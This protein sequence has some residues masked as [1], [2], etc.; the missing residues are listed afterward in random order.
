MQSI[1]KYHITEETVAEELR[2]LEEAKKNPAAFEP[3]YERYYDPIFRY[4]DQRVE[5][6]SSAFDITHQVFV[7]ALTHLHR[8]EFKGVPFASW[9]Y[10]IAKS[11]VYQSI[12]DQSALRARHATSEGLRDLLS[13]S[14]EEQELLLER[15]KSLSHCLT[16]LPEAEWQLIEMRFFEQRP[17]RQIAELVSMTENNAKVKVYRIL[18][19]LKKCIRLTSKAL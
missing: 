8:F 12:K 3:L 1:S 18:E 14:G 9:L 19:K 15:E 10:R 11:E 16:R 17:F 7:K 13:E 4:V 6:R 5:D 2:L